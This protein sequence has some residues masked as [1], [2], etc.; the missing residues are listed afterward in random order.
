MKNENQYQTFVYVVA[1]SDCDLALQK[2]LACQGKA[3]IIEWRLD[4]LTTLDFCT[5]QSIIKTIDF[6]IML[7]LRPQGQG[8][9]FKGSIALRQQYLQKLAGFSPA[10]M[11]V[12]YDLENVWVDQLTA[13]YPNIKL[14]RSWHDCVG[15]GEDLDDRF[16]SMQHPAVSIY[17][18][19]T[20]AT[21]PLEAFRMA[22]WLKTKVK[23][24]KVIGHCM[25]QFSLLSRLLGAIL[26]SYWQ[27]RSDFDDAKLDSMFNTTLHGVGVPNSSDVEWYGLARLN[28][29][30]KLY[31]LI[32]NPVDQSIGD[33]FHNDYFRQHKLN[34]VY[35]KILLRDHEVKKFFELLPGLPFTGFSVTMP[36]KQKVI[37][38]MEGLSKDAQDIGAVN[39][40]VCH[41]DA[42]HLVGHNTDGIGA[43]RA[44][45]SKR[46]I[47]KAR[48]LIIGAGGAAMSVAHALMKQQADLTIVNRTLSKAMALAKKVGGDAFSWD[49]LPSKSFDVVLIAVPIAKLDKQF[50]LPLVSKGSLVMALDYGME[51]EEIKSVIQGLGAQFMKGKS[52]FIHQALSQQ[53]LWKIK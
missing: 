52:M 53:V 25:G 6:P 48:V 32:G 42:G 29:E 39:T 28:S 38:C 12:E 47:Q 17:K 1:E 2:M 7:T 36:L 43:L 19:I 45:Q 41:G 4:Q 15:E 37:P 27:Y 40:V 3:S 20:M 9:F 22:H 51:C 11:D 24:H 13:L 26:G 31:A 10:F 35:V 49:N 8:G 44:I 14:V 50:F 34:A 21:S 5:I 30:T 23:T 16:Q 18:L 46:T 33:Q